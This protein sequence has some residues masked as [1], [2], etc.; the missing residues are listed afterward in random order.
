VTDAPRPPVEPL[1]PRPGEFDEI[2]ARA[3][4]RRHHKLT[5]ALTVTT[6]FLVGV[7]GGA[8]LGGVTGVQDRLGN[9]AAEVIAQETPSTSPTA[10]AE[11]T[12]A[13]R[14][15]KRDRPAPEVSRSAPPTQAPPAVVPS[16]T[17]EP[18]ALVVSGRAVDAAGRPIAGLYVYP[19]QGGRDGFVPGDEPAARTAA[20]GTFS[21]P[22]TH[23]PVLLTPWPVNAPAVAA[24][25]A[26]HAA[27]F[28]GG[29]TDAAIADPARC[30]RSGRPADVRINAGSAVEGLVS[31]PAECLDATHPL[32]LW[33]HDDRGLSVRLPDLVHGAAYRIAGLPPGQHTLGAH[34]NRTQVTVGGGHT[35][36]ADVTFRCTGGA[37]PPLPT[38][39]EPSTSP[40]P[41]PTPSPTITAG[42]VPTDTAAPTSTARPAPSATA[43]ATDGP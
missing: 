39:P 26:T 28:V 19:G 12:L 33:L 11:T 29:A 40:S 16:P 3:R 2:V 8:S 21:L 18:A 17:T 22:C 1:P 4:H 36:I 43:T 41:S 5:T 34:G 24:G 7:A 42:P 38:D 25:A 31:M 35:E 9:L 14:R 10:A 27:T 37:E 15:R 6:V 20:D 23:T 30:T 13:D 32:W